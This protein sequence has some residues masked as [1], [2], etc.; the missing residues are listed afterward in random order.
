MVKIKLA[1]G[2]RYF[3][4]GTTYE[5]GREYLVGEADADHLL[6]QVGPNDV[7][8]FVEVTD[9]MAAKTKTT[10]KVPKAAAA[11]VEDE[12]SDAQDGVSV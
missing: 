8:L 6:S 2:N 3:Y 4:G 1:R 12:G 5:K 10:R 9:R 7:P 11:D